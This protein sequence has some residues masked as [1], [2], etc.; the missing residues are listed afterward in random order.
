MKVSDPSA[1]VDRDAD[2]ETHTP[3]GIPLHVV[4]AEERLLVMITERMYWHGYTRNETIGVLLQVGFGG[5]T[6]TGIGM[7]V[8]RVTEITHA[9]EGARMQKHRDGGDDDT[10]GG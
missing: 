4:S 3:P 6:P 10:S 9:V 1:S 5:I 8:S 7:L 2:T